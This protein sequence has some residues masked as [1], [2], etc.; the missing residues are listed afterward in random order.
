MTNSDNQHDKHIDVIEMLPWFANGSLEEHERQR[1][2]QV[3][4]TC[5]ACK[6]ELEQLQLLSLIHI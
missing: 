3:I 4:D 1:V 6:N 2:Q 5:V